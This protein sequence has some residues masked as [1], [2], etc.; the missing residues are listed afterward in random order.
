MDRPVLHAFVRELAGV[1]QL[2]AG[3]ALA[4]YGRR[5]RVDGCGH[6][7]VRGGGVDVFPTTGREPLRIEF[8]G[9]EVESIR[10]FSPFTQRALDPV[11][12]CTIF[13]AAERRLDLA[14]DWHGEEGR[15]RP[16]PADLVAALDRPPDLVFQPDDVRRI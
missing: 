14:D 5:Q 16:V 12:A 8:F 3:R 10:A 1:E 4:G 6:F 9:D 15:S 7:A 11:E 13:P 2:S